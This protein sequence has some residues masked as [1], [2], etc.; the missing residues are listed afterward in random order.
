MYEASKYTTTED[1][2]NKNGAIIYLEKQD[3][4]RTI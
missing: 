2:F 1:N 3:I 4:S